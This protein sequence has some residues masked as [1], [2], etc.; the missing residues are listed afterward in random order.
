MAGTTGDPWGATPETPPTPPTS[1]APGAVLPELSGNALD[2]IV[3]NQC[4]LAVHLRR[5]TGSVVGRATELS[6]IGQ[7]LKDARSRLSAVTLEGEPGIGKTRL[8]L[9]AAEIASAEGFTV[10]AVTADEEIHGPFLLA[11]SV[12][13]APVFREAVNGT[14]VEASAQRAMEAMS[15]REAPGL[16]GLSADARQLRAFDLAAMALGTIAGVRPLALLIDDTQW[17]DDDTLRM[18]RYVTRTTADRPIFLFL[19]IRPDEFA[20][21]S[22]AVNLVADMERMGLVRRLRLDRFSPLETAELARQLLSGSVDPAS[23]EA[24]HVQS[25]GVPFIVEELIRTYRDAGLLQQIDGVWRLTRNAARLVPSAVRTL[26]G[27]RAGR[28]ASETRA[29][30]SDAAILGRSFSLNDLAAVRGRLDEETV[31]A[32]ELGDRLASAVEA[33]LLLQHPQGSPADFTFTHEQVREFAI[34][35][36][37]QARRRKLHGALVDL[38][39]EAGEP[40]VAALPL[41]ARHALAAGDVERAGRLS[42]EAAQ[43]ALRSNAAEEA[44]RLVEQ[45]LPIVSSPET[46]RLLLTVRDDAYAT[47]RRPSDRLEGLAELAA[48]VEALRDPDLEFDVQLRRAAA[49]RLARDEESAA[50]LARRIRARAAETGNRHAELL[51][52]LELGQAMLGTSLGE[53]FSA[54]VGEAE[55][56]AAEEAFRNAVALGGELADERSVAAALRELGT[57]LIARLR[58]WFGQQRETPLA[59]EFAMRAAAGESVDTLLSSTE[60][61]P[62]LTEARESFERALGIFERLG[63]RTGV[64]S[65]VIAMAYINYA[66]VIHLISSARHLEEIR[67]VVSRMSAMVTESERARLELQLLYGVHV[68][69][70]AKVVPDLMLSRGEEAY[71]SARMLGDRSVEFLAAGGVAMVHAGM[72]EIPDAEAWLEKAS[73]AA[74]TAP[75]PTRARQLELW[76]AIVRGAAG[77]AAGMTRHFELALAKAVEQGRPAARCEVLARQ[78]V[79]AARLGAATNDDALLDLAEASAASVK[80]LYPLL[81]GRAPWNAEADAALAQVRLAR[82]DTEG[83]VTAAGEALHFMQASGH[84]DMSLEILIPA[85]RALLAGGPPEVQAMV[86]GWLQVQVTRIAQATA[87]EGMRVRWLRGPWGRELVELAGPMEELHLAAKP[88]GQPAPSVQLDESDRSLLHLLTQG[89][90]NQEMAAQLGLAED[91][92]AQRLARLLTQIGASTRAEATTMAF[93]GLAL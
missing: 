65:T 29:V 11:Q 37:P 5:V 18:L 46:R 53:G 20:T 81:P 69:A 3:Q 4:S 76:R 50:E 67:H 41:I 87:D 33:G 59:M 88:D 61:A 62:L 86:R 38:M 43:G 19:C 85:G 58:I 13:A 10:V 57:I 2:P 74:S 82:G 9:A 90:T 36:L 22:E 6:I 32:S 24:M 79:E 44:L 72:G 42:V 45:A 80:E 47:L 31:A 1:P 70:R 66:P 27:R 14:A 84:E 63:D 49:L 23:A 71:R 83:A 30:L 48:L 26:I 25:E 28:L 17:A 7:E 54:A 75:T 55:L 12:L 15:G 78:A 64:M 89:S 35:E 56:A 40:S 91:A 39:L 60:L 93:R 8:L 52:N 21:V 68:Y 77:D 51:A 34:D 73:A 92:L 16:E